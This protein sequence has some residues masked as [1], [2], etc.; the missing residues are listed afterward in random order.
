MFWFDN[1]FCFENEYI[2]FFGGTLVGKQNQTIFK[3]RWFDIANHHNTCTSRR[4]Y[5]FLLRFSG[6]GRS[7]A[8]MYRREGWRHRSSPPGSYT[9]RG[10]CWS[11]GSG[12]RGNQRC[13]PQAHLSRQG[14]TAGY[15]MYG[16]GMTI[17]ESSTVIAKLNYW[18]KKVTK[19]LKGR[20]H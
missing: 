2:R 19:H 9:T 15:S 12:D 4:W 6:W 14:S 13:P 3:K 18:R 7:E 1:E 10:C 17:C 11:R 20:R 8:C 5:L 16:T